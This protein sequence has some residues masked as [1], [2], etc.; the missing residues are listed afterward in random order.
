MSDLIDR[1]TA[2]KV[3]TEYYHHRTDT[4][5]QALREALSRVPSA[6]QTEWIPCSERMPEEYKPVLAQLKTYEMIIAWWSKDDGWETDVFGEFTTDYI[7]KAD[8]EVWMPLP[9]HYKG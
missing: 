3:L 9:K 4:Q 8:I 2:Y 6:E 5:H 7:D 1:E